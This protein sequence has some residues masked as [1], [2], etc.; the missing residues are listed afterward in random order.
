MRPYNHVFPKKTMIQF[1]ALEIPQLERFLE[2]QKAGLSLKTD[3]DLDLILRQ[4][5]QKANEF[6]PAESGSMPRISSCGGCHTSCGGCRGCRNGSR[7][8]WHGSI[9]RPIHSAPR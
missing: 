8:S 3:I 6:V 7:N 4:I 2:R 5:L 1:H 9:P